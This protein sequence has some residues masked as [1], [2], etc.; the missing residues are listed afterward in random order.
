MAT[1]YTFA[2]L[3]APSQFM[4]EDE[5]IF[6][7]EYSEDLV[8][9]EATLVVDGYT[10]YW[11]GSEQVPAYNYGNY[12][13]SKY[14]HTSMGSTWDVGYEEFRVPANSLGITPPP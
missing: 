6:K 8:S 2:R 7:L 1:Q 12:Q 4:P 10:D 14:I 9:T 5:V 11:P 13:Q 3:T